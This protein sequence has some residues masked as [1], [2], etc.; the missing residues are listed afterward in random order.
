MDWI[1]LAEDVVQWHG[2]VNA[3]M[4]FRLKFLDQLNGYQLIK[5]LLCSVG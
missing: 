2:V 3:V 1:C 5:T 4:N